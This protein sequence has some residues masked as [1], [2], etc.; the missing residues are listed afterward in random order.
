[1]ITKLLS[2]EH[3]A[4]IL[5]VKRRFVYRLVAQGRIPF[6]RVGRYIRFRPEAIDEWMEARSTE[7][8]RRNL[9]VIG[10]DAEARNTNP[11]LAPK[12]K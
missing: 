9:D 1:M 5:A 7:S 12:A 11:T 10:P 4:G 3:V 8:A 6:L 2:V